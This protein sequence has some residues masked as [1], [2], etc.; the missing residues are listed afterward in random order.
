[1]GTR[2]PGMARSP[3]SRYGEVA[4]RAG[5]ARSPH[6][7]YSKAASQEP[8]RLAGSSLPPLGLCK[9]DS[10]GKARKVIECICLV[11]KDYGEESEGLHIVQEEYVKSH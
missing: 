9:I 2:L 1:M 8:T 3:R 5:K 7:W 10:G 11:V 4:S 6:S